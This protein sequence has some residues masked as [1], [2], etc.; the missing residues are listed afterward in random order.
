MHNPV[1]KT[2]RSEALNRIVLIVVYDL[3]SNRSII[4][5]EGTAKSSIAPRPKRDEDF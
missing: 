1:I 5:A 3:C 4:F 2:S